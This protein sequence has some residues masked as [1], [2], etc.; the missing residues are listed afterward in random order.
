MYVLGENQDVVPMIMPLYHIYG[1]ALCIMGNI[2]H[3][4]KTITLPKF[5]PDTFI[6]VLKNHKVTHLYGAPP[7]SKQISI[8]YVINL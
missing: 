8:T 6:S 3:G 5:T 1:F 2:F 4:S 7:L